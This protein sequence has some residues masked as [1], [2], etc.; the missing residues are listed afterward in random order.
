MAISK[1]MK[2]LFLFSILGFV[3]QHS[4][5]AIGDDEKCIVDKAK[6]VSDEG[7]YM[8]CTD[9]SLVA[10]GKTECCSQEGSVGCCKPGERWQKMVAIAVGIS[11]TF[12]LLALLY[13]YLFWCKRGTVPCLDRFFDRAKRKYYAMEDSVPC[14]ASRTEQRKQEAEIM[15]KS[16]D[17]PA[18]S[19]PPEIH[20]ETSKD[21]WWDGQFI[22]NE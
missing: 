14:C 12:I 19:L 21:R 1:F 6:P 5:A 13:I 9:E 4:D 22:K 8:D 3:F 18:L 10:Q 17:Q 20:D 7:N 15:A 16:K 2:L 11:V